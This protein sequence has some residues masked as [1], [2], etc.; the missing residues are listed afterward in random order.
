MEAT[1]SA[2]LISVGQSEHSVTVI[3]EITNDFWN[4]GRS[5]HVHARCTTMVTI[6]SQASGDTG[7]KIWISGLS[8]A[9]IVPTARTGCR[10][11]RR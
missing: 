9:L 1:P 2:V 10:A 11:A 5:R 8:A 7:L 6:G 3:A 4:S